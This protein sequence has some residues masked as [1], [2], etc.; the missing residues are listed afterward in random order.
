VDYARHIIG[1]C[2]MSRDLDALALI[3]EACDKAGPSFAKTTLVWAPRFLAAAGDFDH[4][5]LSKRRMA[6]G[7]IYRILARAYEATKQYDAAEG[8]LMESF[9]INNSYG[10]STALA[11]FYL[12]MGRVDDAIMRLEECR[13]LHYTHMAYLGSDLVWEPHTAKQTRELNIYLRNVYK[14][15]DLR[16]AEICGMKKRH[17]RGQDKVEENP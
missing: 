2:G 10:Q 6:H 9:K 7:R 11:D 15:V 17:E 4:I 1:L 3:V 14:A 5:P 13:A 12:R 8:A 16:L